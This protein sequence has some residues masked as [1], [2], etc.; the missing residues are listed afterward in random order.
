MT[1]P[2]PAPVLMTG[3]VDGALDLAGAVGVVGEE[4]DVDVEGDEEGFVLGGEDV[5]EELGAGLLLEGED[6]H[7]AAGGVEEDA[8]GER[9]VLFLGEVL[10]LLEALVLEDA[11]VVLV[12]VGDE[13]VLV[14]DGEVD[15]DEVDV[16]LEGLGVGPVDGLGF[17]FAGGRR[18]AGGGGLL[19]VEDGGERRGRG[20]SGE[21]E[22]S[23]YPIRRR[24][25]RIGVVGLR[26]KRGWRVAESAD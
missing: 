23:A 17:G 2:V 10:G 9:E 13:A 14:A 18:A 15:V 21:A 12:E 24:K 25:R 8:D 11:A 7:L 20:R 6:V 4:V 19:R 1:E 3:L 5:F 26:V 16:D 22:R